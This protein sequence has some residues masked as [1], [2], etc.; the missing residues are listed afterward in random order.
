MKF[1]E[2]Y[3]QNLVLIAVGY[4]FPEKISKLIE[5][6]TRLL[7]GLAAQLVTAERAQLHNGFT[8]SCSEPFGLGQ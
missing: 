3:Q 8:I 6:W 2:T 7:Q 5:K 4:L 1:H